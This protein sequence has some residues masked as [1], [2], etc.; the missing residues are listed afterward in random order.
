M[1]SLNKADFDIVHQKVI[2]AFVNMGGSEY[3]RP[4]RNEILRVNGWS[5]EEYEGE[6]LVRFTDCSN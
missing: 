4:L 5:Y 3:F 6:C 1:V 2:T